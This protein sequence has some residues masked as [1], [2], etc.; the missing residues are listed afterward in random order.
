MAPGYRSMSIISHWYWSVGFIPRSVLL[1]TVAAEKVGGSPTLAAIAEIK[2]ES[3]R[4]KEKLT[5]RNSDSKR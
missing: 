4:E 3:D 5:L 2:S 1:I